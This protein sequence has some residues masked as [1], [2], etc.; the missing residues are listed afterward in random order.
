MLAHIFCL[1]SLLAWGSGSPT[2]S[3]PRQH[4]IHEKRDAAPPGWTARTR[5]SA[6]T[7]I[8]LRI[9]LKQRNLELGGMYLDEVSNPRSDKYAQHWT[10]KRVME[11]FSPRS[12]RMRFHINDKWS[13]VCGPYGS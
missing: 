8:P 7:R 6:D 9:G 12:A 4:V 1:A 5:L 13:Y 3:A 2:P 10:A 11:T